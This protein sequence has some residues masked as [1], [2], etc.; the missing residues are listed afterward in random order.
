MFPSLGTFM[1]EESGGSVVL[2]DMYASLFAGCSAVNGS[3]GAIFLYV[4]VL[5]EYEVGRACFR[6]GESNPLNRAA[7]GKNV[8]L[9][10][11]CEEEFLPESTKPSFTPPPSKM[12][13][14]SELIPQRV[15]QAE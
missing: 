8:Y 3:G 11:N 10:S 6:D 14:N 5:S 9:S 13:P 15:A 12:V 7:H 1:L 2:G 4:G